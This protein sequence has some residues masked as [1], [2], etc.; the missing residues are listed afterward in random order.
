MARKPMITRTIQTT[1]ANVLYLNIAEEKPFYSEVSLP[2]TYKSEKDLFKAVE[3]L[4][5]DP[6]VKPV[7]VADVRVNETLYGMTEQEFISLAKVLPPR[8]AT[9]VSESEGE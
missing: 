7:H 3:S 5:T 1:V 2:R 6:N 8:K 9:E 4:S